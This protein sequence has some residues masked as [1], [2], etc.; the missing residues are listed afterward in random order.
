[1]FGRVHGVTR[2]R[3]DQV[4]RARGGKLV[5]KPSTRVTLTALAHS[6]ASN[7]LFDGRVSLPA[8]LPASAAM[9]SERDLRRRLGLLPPPDGIDRSLKLS[10]NARGTAPPCPCEWTGT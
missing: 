6:A 5:N 9:L 7:A 2:R 3:L 8:G 1:M 4:V 10:D